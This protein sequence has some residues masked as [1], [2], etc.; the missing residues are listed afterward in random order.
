MWSSVL[1]AII[2]GNKTRQEMCSS[3]RRKW[4]VIG[5]YKDIESHLYC[6]LYVIYFYEWMI[7]VL[8]HDSALLRLH[9]AGNNLGECYIFHKP[10]WHCLLMLISHMTLFTYVNYPHGIVSRLFSMRYKGNKAKHKRK[11]VAVNVENYRNYV[12]IQY[13]ICY[14]IFKWIKTPNCLILCYTVI[15]SHHHSINEWR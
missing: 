8:G 15:T 10:A 4:F 9:W 14:L 12:I 5:T 3:K 13:H 1:L 2:S 11:C 7:G 6:I